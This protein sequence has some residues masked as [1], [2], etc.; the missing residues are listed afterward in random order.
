[1]GITKT[2]LYSEQQNEI[3]NIL[4]VLG[5]P[6]RLAII[7]QLLQEKCC[8][9][10]DFTDEIPLAQPTISRHLKELKSIG[11]IAGTVEGNSI[12]YC[13]QPQRWRAIQ[14]IIHDLFNSYTS[15]L[16]CDC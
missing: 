9:C 8:I 3:A 16:S 7:Q 5:H 11:I 13:I 14:Q 6:A 4:K 15:D 1:M 10:G 2:E 12:S